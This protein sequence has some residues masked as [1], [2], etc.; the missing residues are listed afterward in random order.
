MEEEFDTVVL[1]VWNYW[2]DL[3]PLGPRGLAGLAVENLFRTRHP[4]EDNNNPG[5]FGSFS[6]TRSSI[7]IFFY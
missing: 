3:A 5:I 6:F 7:L 1:E 4:T 2:W